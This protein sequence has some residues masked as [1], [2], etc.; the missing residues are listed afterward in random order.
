MTFFQITKTHET[1]YSL[2]DS[3]DSLLSKLDLAIDDMGNGRVKS[4]EE[5]WKEI[6]LL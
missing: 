2:G 6:D 1:S 3:I 5:A 4:L